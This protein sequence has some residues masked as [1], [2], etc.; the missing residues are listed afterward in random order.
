MEKKYHVFAM[1]AALVDTEI[2]VSDKD[3]ENL[4]VD[5][6]LMPLVDES[7]QAELID[8]LSDHLTASR[9]ASG[10]SA[11]NSIIAVSAFGGD[12]FLQGGGR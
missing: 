4:A 10:G 7:R 12:T 1:G 5:K 2:E 11:A 6:G 3:L 8:Y 9:R